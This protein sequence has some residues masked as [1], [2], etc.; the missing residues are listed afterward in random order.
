[1]M[2]KAYVKEVQDVINEG[3]T[4][5]V[6]V[7]LYQVLVERFERM[8]GHAETEEFQASL[9]ELHKTERRFFR[10]WIFRFPLPVSLTW[11]EVKFKPQR[12]RRCEICGDYFYNASRNGKRVTCYKGDRCE[13]EYEVRRKRPGTVID[14]IYKRRVHEV[15]VDMAPDKRD[16]VGNAILTEMELTAWESGQTY[17]IPDPS[18]FDKLR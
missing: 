8:S 9:A 3:L 13:R 15:P 18:M 14:P 7:L 1:M 16:N 6:A 11:R 10:D 5:E 17:G 12:V 2:G 4:D